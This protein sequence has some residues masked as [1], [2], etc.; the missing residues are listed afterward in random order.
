MRQNYADIHLWTAL[1]FKIEKKTII[2]ARDPYNSAVTSDIQRSKRMS[3]SPTA[4]IITEISE[5]KVSC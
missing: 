3:Q 4:S 2:E 5:K 1:D